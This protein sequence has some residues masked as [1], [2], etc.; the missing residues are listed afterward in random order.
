MRFTPRPYQQAAHDAVIAHWR[1]SPLPIVV[2][3]ATGSGKSLIISLIA[4]TLNKLSKGKRVLCLA[5]SRE[6]VLQNAEKYGALGEPYSIYSA[7]VRKELR[8]QVVYATEGTFK[9]VAKRLGSQFAGVIIYEAHRITPTIQKIIEDMRKSNPLLRV[10]GLSATPYR[11]NTG[12][13]YG[14]DSDGKAMPDFLANNPYFYKCV[15]EI[16]ARFLV[17]QGYLTPLRAGAINS[18]SYDVSGLKVQSNGMYS[19]ATVKAAFEGWGRATAAIVNDV[20]AQTQSATGVMIFAA[21]V[22]HAEE[23]MASLHPDNA[24]L[25]TGATKK[26]EREKTLADFKDRR[27]MYLVNVSVLTTGFDAPNVS[28]IAILRATESVSLLQQ[29]MG[30]GMR[31]F[32]GK[33]ECVVLDYAKNL[34]KHMP[35]GDLYA[36]IV[37]AAGEASGDG[38]LECR[39]E[40][41]GGINIFAK[42]PNQG[43]YEIDGNGYF[44]DLAGYRVQVEVGDKDKSKPLPAH[45]GRRCQQS[46]HRTCER[47]SY[48]WSSKDCPACNHKNDIT[49]R[50]CSECKTELINPNDK[51]VAMHAEH[52]KDPTIMQTDE[53]VSMTHRVGV[54]RAGN[55]MV[56]VNFMTSHRQFSIYLTEVTPY[57][58]KIKSDIMAATGDLDVPPKTITYRKEG[59]FWRV[60]AFDR[61]TDI[62]QLQRKL[63]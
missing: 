2:N 41:C 43:G 53:L 25:I 47:C 28:H 11:L 52:K 30:R 12:F 59:D 3:A 6:L 10:C 63:A 5:P 24:R 62:E 48:Y 31:L 8:H 40:Q 22:K 38:V 9:S 35:D 33:D 49:A 15:Y 20:V 1:K 27:F 57:Q 36:P 19:S 61:P 44:T 58:A 18:T 17:E 60:H 42:R 39:C 23:I 56:T 54:S 34:E 55:D 16:G 7:S 37:K 4:K 51:L 46:T 26:D 45:Y 21:T 13:I 14:I 29:I 50:M 32:N